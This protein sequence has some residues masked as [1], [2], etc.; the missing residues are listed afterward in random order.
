MAAGRLPECRFDLVVRNAGRK[1]EQAQCA[2]VLVLLRAPFAARAPARLS[3]RFAHS[4]AKAV[5][6]FRRKPALGD[7][8][9]DDAQNIFEW[10]G[11]KLRRGSK[12][13][14]PLSAAQIERL[15][16][17]HRVLDGLPVVSAI[18]APLRNAQIEVGA[19]GAFFRFDEHALLTNATVFRLARG[20]SFCQRPRPRLLLLA[21][22]APIPRPLRGRNWVSSR[23]GALGLRRKRTRCAPAS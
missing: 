16:Q 17:R 4:F 7:I 6:N 10:N 18:P 9:L 23:R 11:S 5:Q 20:A 2:C 21:P 15:A 3:S 19:P 12:N 22:F 13:F 14:L 1:A 8:L